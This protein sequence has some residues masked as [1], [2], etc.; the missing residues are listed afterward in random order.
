MVRYVKGFID[1][2]DIYEDLFPKVRGYVGF[3]LS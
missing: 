3:C 2:Y 1:Y